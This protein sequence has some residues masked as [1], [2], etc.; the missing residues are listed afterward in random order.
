MLEK[1]VG[2]SL[3]VIG[4]ECFEFSHFLKQMNLKNVKQIGK[5][6]FYRTS[7][8]T[9]KNE[10]IQ[11][12]NKNQFSQLIANVQKVKMKSL[13]SLSTSAFANCTIN[14]FDAPNIK[15]IA[16]DKNK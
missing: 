16:I 3:E 14:E 4:K 9:I 13:S 6:A 2:D 12:L 15:T 10:H 7:L 5:A 11:V 1:F 8:N